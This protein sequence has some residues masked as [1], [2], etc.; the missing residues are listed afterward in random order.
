MV[1]NSFMLCVPSEPCRLIKQ[2]A[3][4]QV[5][6]ATEGGKVHKTV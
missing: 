1:M 3:E 4:G 5:L 6:P 2:A